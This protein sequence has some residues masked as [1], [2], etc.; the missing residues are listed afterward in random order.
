MLNKT[1]YNAIWKAFDEEPHIVNEGSSAVIKLPPPKASFLPVETKIPARNVEGGEQYTVNCPFCGDRRHRLYFSYMWN[2]PIKSGN[3]IYRCTDHLVRCFNEEC[4]KDQSNFQKM[5]DMILECMKEVEDDV[6]FSGAAEHPPLES[7]ANQAALPTLTVPINR[8]GVP[9]FIKQYVRNRG[10]NADDLYEKWGV[11]VG[12][13]DRAILHGEAPLK[14]P[15]II[16][17]VNQ[18]GNFWFWQGR[19]V[20]LNGE[21]DGDLERKLDGSEYAKYIIPHGAKKRWALYN[22]DRALQ[23]DEIGIVEGVTDCWSVGENCICPF[24]KT[25]SP[26]Q[27]AILTERARGKR[28]VFIP[29]MDDP[30]A[31]QLAEHNAM[32]LKAANVTS[33]VSIAKLPSGTDPGDLIRQMKKGEIWKYIKSRIA[34]PVVNIFMTGGSPVNR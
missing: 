28:L 34:S 33:D 17:P 11:L 26:A 32:R 23:H 6:E 18:F 9:D 8:S 12:R 3:L 5:R 14:H 1:L 24:G 30:E 31:Y 16:V 10:W 4:Q 20:P 27:F 29:D 22:I 15:I 21:L 19:L 13:P 25:L 7:I 2:Q